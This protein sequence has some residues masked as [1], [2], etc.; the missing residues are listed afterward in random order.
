[1]RADIAVVLRRLEQ[2]RGTAMAATARTMLGTLY[3][4]AMSQGLIENN[5]V[6]GTTKVEYSGKRERVLN[7]EEL[8][9][10]WRA[11]SNPA[12]FPNDGN[13]GRVIKLLILLGARRR[14]IECMQWSE[15]DLARATWT[16]PAERSKNHR[17]HTLP[18]SP[19][20]LAILAEIS[21]ETQAPEAYLFSRFGNMDGG[22]QVKKLQK[23]TGIRTR[24][25]GSGS[26]CPPGGPDCRQSRRPPDR[27]RW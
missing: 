5:P 25:G 13:F 12:N 18:L 27:E 9:I 17:A 11:C 6:I 24:T 19:A 7:D 4:W 15:L 26:G 21:N 1:T 16:L 14:E 10:V 22:R 2:E 3:A 20:A 23:Q 8:A